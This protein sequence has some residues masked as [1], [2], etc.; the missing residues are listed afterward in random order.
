[1]HGE[2]RYIGITMLTISPQILDDLRVRL[3]LPISV[4]HGIVVFRIVN[5]SPA[6]LVGIQPGDVI[7]KINGVD[8][9]GARD[10]YKLLEG[11]NDLKMTVIRKE[12]K[13]VVSVRPQ[14]ISD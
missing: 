2:R 6:H 4:T 7:T 12:K 9:Y 13:F 11:H 1:M 5:D 14:V 8:I 3:D 10:V